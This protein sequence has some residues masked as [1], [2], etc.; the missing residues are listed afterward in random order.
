MRHAPDT[1]CCVTCRIGSNRAERAE[2]QTRYIPI[3]DTDRLRAEQAVFSDTLLDLPLSGPDPLNHKQMVALC[4][5]RLKEIGA[6]VGLEQQ[7]IGLLQSADSPDVPMSELAL[8]LGYSERSLRRRLEAEG[9][10]YREISDLVRESQARAL[11]SGSSKPIQQIAHEL[12]FEKASNFSR[13]F[14][15]WTGQSSRD[16]RESVA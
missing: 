4:D 6:D 15:R 2:A 16:F 1:S 8:Q 5:A 3:P 7:V 12:G 9:V 11:L 14:K 10:T 13:S